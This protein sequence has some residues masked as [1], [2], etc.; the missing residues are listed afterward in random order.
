MSH[1]GRNDPCPCG[2]GKKF[3]RCCLPRSHPSSGPEIPA[4]VMAR[5]QEHR[6]KEQLRKERYG[7]VRPIIHL[8]YQGHKFVGVGNQLLYANDWKTF[9]DFLMDYIQ[10]TLDSDWGN[11]EL[12]KPFDERHQILK[13]YDG[14]CRFQRRQKR[15]K[16]GLYGAVPNGVS[17][18]Y[19]CL[20]YDLYI[21]KDHTALQDE[22]VRRLKHPDQFQGARYEVSVTATCIRAGFEIH[23]EDESDPT[24][25]HPE[26]VGVHKKTGQEISV[27]AKSRHRPGILGFPGDNNEAETKADI[28]RLLNKAIMKAST[29][30]FV[31]FVDLNLPPSSGT[32]FDKPWFKEVLETVDQLGDNDDPFNLL[33]FTNHPHHYGRDDSPDPEKDFLSVLSKRPRVAVD[34][35]QVLIELVE[36][37]NQYGNIP[38]AFPEDY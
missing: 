10:G 17:A 28:G 19:L 4:E 16:D 22:L 34:Y 14:L 18:A 11:S 37:V 35:P 8:N 24:R 20:A 2:S 33:T 5:F 38:N 26:F 15:N 7:Q 36:A 3:K 32:V 29:H 12:A 25:K 23:F 1:I 13:W 27:E 21:L 9:P 31:I 30:P 6:R